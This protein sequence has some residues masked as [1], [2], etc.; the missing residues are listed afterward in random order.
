MAK[1][2]EDS[3]PQIFQNPI[4]NIL[5]VYSIHSLLVHM[6]LLKLISQILNFTIIGMSKF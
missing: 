1:T 6:K 5:I 2:M 3:A 4:R